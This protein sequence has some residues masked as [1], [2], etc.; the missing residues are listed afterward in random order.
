MRNMKKY[1]ILGIAALFVISILIETGCR[2][3]D[4]RMP[5]ESAKETERLTENTQPETSDAAR[6]ETGQEEKETKETAE[7][8]AAGQTPE[9]PE[10]ETAGK[11]ETEGGQQ[12]SAGNAPSVSDETVWTE[13][14]STA[15]SETDG[16]RR[17]LSRH[18]K[19]EAAKEQQRE[20]EVIITPSGERIVIDQEES[21][22]KQEEETASGG[23]STDAPDEENAGSDGMPDEDKDDGDAITLPFIPIR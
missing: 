7:T 20:T 12:N 19:A 6:P 15:Q 13:D 18:S 2:R 23:E 17:G 5:A 1:R 11:K 21:S 10:K 16:K 14:G 4:T 8:E 3:K 22:E 9:E